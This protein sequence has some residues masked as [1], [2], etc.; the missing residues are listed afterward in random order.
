MKLNLFNY[1]LPAKLIAQKP[2][3]QRDKSK[4]LILDVKTKKVQ[5]KHF[6]DLEN[7]LTSNDVLVVNQTK[8]IPAR[9]FGKKLTGGKIEILLTEKVN[10]NTWQVMIGGRNLKVKDKIYFKKKLEATIVK[11]IDAKVWQIKFNKSGKELDRI[12]EQIG[13]TPIPPYIK[14]KDS[15]SVRQRYQT[16]YAKSKGSV[17]APTAGLHFSPQ[18]IAK[19]KA[20]GV[21]IFKIIL[22]IG[23]GTFEPVTVDDITKHK[24]HH[25]WAS[26]D[27][28]TARELNK[29]KSQGKNIITVGTTTA[30][31]LEAFSAKGKL[32][33]GS[34]WVGIY[35]YPSYKF[36]FVN[37][38]ITNFHLSKSSLLFM[39]SALAGRKLILDTYQKAIKQ[40]Y[41]FY[42][43]GDAMYIKK[44]P[45]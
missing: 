15:Q 32:N 23:L 31:A 21:K 33:S 20:K 14:T 42:S 28:K 12:I 37:D 7:I 19:L 36:K 41:R 45:H 22:H 24:I 38:L 5:H 44:R 1:N 17:A 3:K 30:R 18:L 16:V 2:L 34:K 6:T 8:V 26:I 27:I 25:E 35:I 4:L 40:K 29:L 39:I 43:F 10:S 13:C 9:L 11:D